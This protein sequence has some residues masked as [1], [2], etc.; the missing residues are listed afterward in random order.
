MNILVTGGAGYKGVKLSKALLDKGHKVT[1]LDNFMY[2]FSSVFHLVPDKNFTVVSKDIRNIEKEDVRGY[3]MIYHLAGISGY[4]ACE[5]NPH[6]AQLINVDATDK[7]AKML[8]KKQ[9]LVYAST[10]SFYGSS[11]KHMDEKS[12]VNPVSLYGIT[13]YKAERI[14]MKRDNSVALRFATLFG[15]SPK[16]R[17]SLMVND[18][19]HRAISERSLVLFDSK[20]VRTFLHLDDAISAYVMVSENP[21]KFIGKVFNVG[22]DNMNFSKL[23]LAKKIKKH[24]DFKIID[25]TLADFDKRDF[26]IDYSRISKLGFKATKTIDDGIKELVKLYSFYEPNMQYNF[27]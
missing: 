17:N 23:E 18:F 11:G 21:S 4:P 8:L 12:K 16:M 20:S 15:V 2:G 13:K 10:T 27:I 6:S 24:V 1:V 7:I 26:I 3:D 14:V 19:V 25:S 5:A 9:I 22:D